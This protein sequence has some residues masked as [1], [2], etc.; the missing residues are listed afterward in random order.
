MASTLNAHVVTESEPPVEDSIKKQFASKVEEVG[1]EFVGLPSGDMSQ[2]DI[3]QFFAGRYVFLTGA[4]G[5]VGKVSNSA[6]PFTF[7][8]SATKI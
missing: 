3:A 4:T 7:L 2:Q 5:F 8:G 6:F 1:D